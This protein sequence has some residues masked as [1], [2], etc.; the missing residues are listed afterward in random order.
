MRQKFARAH[1]VWVRCSKLVQKRACSTVALKSRSASRSAA[2]P[3]ELPESAATAAQALV[4]GR[5]TAGLGSG[6]RREAT[7]RAIPP[8]KR[9]P[10]HVVRCRC[11]R[12]E[13]RK[14]FQQRE[15][16]HISKNSRASR[17]RQERTLEFW[18]R[19]MHFFS[20][21]RSLRRK[22]TARA[23]AVGGFSAFRLSPSIA[24]KS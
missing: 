11:V 14:C 23:C 2:G 13:S 19:L 21:S 3:R 8:H 15:A 1:A 20:Y 10:R 17:D 12:G 4:D 7:I 5:G 24:S 6:A 16:E 18:K 9:R 22:P